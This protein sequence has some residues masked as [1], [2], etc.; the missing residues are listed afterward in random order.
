MHS[1]AYLLIKRDLYLLDNNPVDGIDIEPISDENIFDLTLFLRP[2]LGSMWFGSMFRIFCSFYDTFNVQPPVL[3]FDQMHIPYHPNVDPITGRVNVTASEKWSSRFTLR[4][5]LDELV[6]AFTTP[7]EKALI[8]SDAMRMLK[9]R[10]S[11]YQAIIHESIIK[12]QHLMD[13]IN[14]EKSNLG[15]SPGFLPKGK[16]ANRARLRT[17]VIGARRQRNNLSFNQRVSFEDYL[18]TWKGIATSKPNP[19]DENPLLSYL[20]LQP[21]LQAQHLALNPN[22]LA[23]QLDDRAIQFERL[24]YGKLTNDEPTRKLVQVSQMSLAENNQRQL[25]VTEANSRIDETSNY[26]N[27]FQIKQEPNIV[28]SDEVDELLQ[29]TQCLPDGDEITEEN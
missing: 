16:D 5:L 17:P 4:S 21:K 6:N 9:Y 19:N 23:R 18:N 10:P 3:Q 25:V 8:N 7:D 11:D 28:Q 26:E 15:R 13:S 29:W 27:S 24:K 12:S 1:R 22:E 14:D 20:S 2:R